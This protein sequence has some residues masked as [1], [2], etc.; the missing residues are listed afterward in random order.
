MVGIKW[1][2]FCKSLAQSLLK[3]CWIQEEIISI[4]NCISHLPTVE[5]F[6][7]YKFQLPH[8]FPP[9]LPSSVNSPWFH[10]KHTPCSLCEGTSWICLTEWVS[11]YDLPNQNTTLLE[12]QWL[13]RGWAHDKSLPRTFSEATELKVLSFPMIACW[14][15]NIC[16]E[17]NWPLLTTYWEILH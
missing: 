12:S 16:L 10:G 5:D 17:S 7:M 2:K 15:C 3:Q 6:K 1:A 11:N 4:Q 14:K 8:A 13:D 9:S